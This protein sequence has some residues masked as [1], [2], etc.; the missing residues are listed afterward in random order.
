MTFHPLNTAKAN[1]LEVVF[2]AVVG[3]LVITAVD[4]RTGQKVSGF[5][6]GLPLIGKFI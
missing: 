6:R 5:F 2:W 4:A 1:K 3:F